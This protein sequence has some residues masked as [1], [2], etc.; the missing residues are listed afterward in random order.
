MARVS[1]VTRVT[2]TLGVVAVLSAA[3][4]LACRGS[5]D[6]ILDLL[7]KLERAAEAR[8]AGP[9]E[10]ALAADFRARDGMT[11]AEAAGLLRRYFAAY[12]SIK[13]EVY[14]VSVERGDDAARLTFRADVD[15]RPLRVGPLA[16]FL[17]PEAMARFDLGLKR[18]GKRWLIVSAAWQEI[19]T[20]EAEVPPAP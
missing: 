15:G 14:D 1:R 18:E 6:P 10:A 17:P 12:E 11:R 13:L 8:D 19:T 3:L 9:I 2:K 4:A 5:R 7:K 16:A 20:G